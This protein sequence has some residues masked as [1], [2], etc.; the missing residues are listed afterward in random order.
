MGHI[1]DREFITGDV[2]IT[3]QEVRAV[4]I[5]KLRLDDNSILVDVGAGTGSIAVEASTYIRDG[6]VYA[7]EK[8]AKACDLIK[9]NIEKFHCSNLTLIEGRAPEMIPEI[10]YNRMFIG[11]STGSLREILLHFLKNAE[12]NGIIVLNAIALET[13]NSALSL[14]KELNF[15]EIEVCN[16]A[17]SRGRKV[18]GYT[19]MYGENPIFIISA[20]KGEGD[21]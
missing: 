18:G 19:M 11:G 12:K 3:K 10:K 9:K 13:L 20:K 6:K 15:A 1:Y 21:E 2:P 5:S 16:V 8:E 4:S 7:V 14:L 17:V